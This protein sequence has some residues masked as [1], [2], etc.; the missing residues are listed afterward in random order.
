MKAK[1]AL[2]ASLIS[3]LA[4]PLVAQT[5]IVRVDGSSTVY[6]LTE[7]VAE[8]FQKAKG[9]AVNVTV[10]IAGT[11][12]GFKKFLRKET[13]INDA[14]RP[15][16]SQELEEARR[17][18]IKF[19][20][21]PVAFDAL[22]VV[23]NPGNT[24]VDH[25]TTSEL[26]RMWAPEAQGKITNWK[27]IRPTFPDVPLSLFGPGSDSGTF[28]YFTEVIVGKPKSSRGDYMASEDD[29]VLVQGVSKEKGALGYFGYA[30]YVENRNRLKVVPIDN[31]SGPVEP[32]EDTV[33]NGK[34]T[35]LSR[36]LFIYVNAESL[37][38]PEVAEFVQFYLDHVGDLA[39]DVGFIPLPKSAYEKAKSRVKEQRT[40][41]I[42]VGHSKASV[43]IDELF[44]GTLH[45]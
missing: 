37:K 19:I 14:S 26:Q 29:N 18:G 24:W 43:T 44:H 8:E 7:A 36:P 4:A 28:D 45:N 11:G 39:K 23:V 15:I 32:S 16:L 34:Y 2:V 25:L 6:P 42:F 30:Y 3:A 35:P 40:G 31:G 17:Q 33:H 41:T 22:S 5:P 12:G 13:D 27:Q 38:R 1:I 10:G 9:G 20:E 21:L